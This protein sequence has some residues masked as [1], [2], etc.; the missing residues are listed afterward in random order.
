MDSEGIIKVDE[1]DKE[2]EEIIKNVARF[3]RA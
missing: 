3:A 1:I 2:A